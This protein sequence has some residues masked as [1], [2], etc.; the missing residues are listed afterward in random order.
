MILTDICFRN[1]RLKALIKELRIRF[2]EFKIGFLKEVI[3]NLGYKA[4]FDKGFW[5]FSRVMSKVRQFFVGAHNVFHDGIWM[6][7][8]VGIKMF[9]Y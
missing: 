6:N 1:R 5:T 2:P 9:E 8:F 7:R 4:G 3:Q